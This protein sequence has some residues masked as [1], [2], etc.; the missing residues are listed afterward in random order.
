[1]IWPQKMTDVADWSQLRKSDKS[2][3]FHF[4]QEIMVFVF[5]GLNSGFKSS[6]R[7]EADLFAKSEDLAE[8]AFRMANPDLLLCGENCVK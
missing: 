5:L 7:S 1:M 3:E 2:N 4:D 6:N 8:K